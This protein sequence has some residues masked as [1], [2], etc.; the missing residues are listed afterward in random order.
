MIEVPLSAVF[1]ER[2]TPV[3]RDIA[4]LFKPLLGTNFDP[5]DV[6]AAVRITLHL[7]EDELED[8]KRFWVWILVLRS[9]RI[10][11]QRAR[12]RLSE[13]EEAVRE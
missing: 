1:N 6:V 12:V 8:R 13:R 4:K 10:L 3:N 2:G 9:Y 7:Q 5:F 11:R